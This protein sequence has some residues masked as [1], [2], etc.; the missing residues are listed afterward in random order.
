MHEFD[1][2]VLECFLKKQLQLFPEPVAESL[3]E[4]ENFLEECMAVVV[5]S[6][7]EVIEFFEDEGIDM[8]GAMDDEILEADEVF[9]IGDGR[10]L[11]VEG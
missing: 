7:D 5:N 10:Y 2:A 11:I 3:E 6:V 8:E 4:A 9:D 1:D